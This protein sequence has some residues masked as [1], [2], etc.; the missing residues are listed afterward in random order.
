MTYSLPEEPRLG[1]CELELSLKYKPRL[2]PAIYKVYGRLDILDGNMWVAKAVFKNSGDSN[3][4][5]LKI[6][7][8]LGEYS[9]RS[10]PTTYSLV[11][12][13]GYVI[14]LYYP[15][16][17]SRISE[18]S[19]RTPVDIRVKY[20]F[21]DEEGGAYS[22][23]GG[24]RAE[25]LGANQL[26]FSNIAP[27]ETTGTWAEN[28]SNSPLLEE[29]EENLALQY[30]DFIVTSRT[31][32]VINGIDTL[33]VDGQSISTEGIVLIHTIVLPYES[34]LAKAIVKC[35]VLKDQYATLSPI[36]EY[37]FDSITLL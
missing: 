30:S 2:I 1:Y 23:M 37:I 29:I 21:R 36:L 31:K 7:Y 20:E 27:E 14:D 3:V 26:E 5:N 15:I 18:L 33:R 12:P 6:S 35:D 28:F 8:K 25:I 13:E 34:N 9:D 4:R 22:E 11:V 32:V 19:S 24:E 10:I 17:F 16:I